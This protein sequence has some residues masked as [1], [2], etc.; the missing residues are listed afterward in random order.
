MAM[1][2]QP[3]RGFSFDKAIALGLAMIVVAV[4]AKRARAAD[5]AADVD[6]TLA[7]VARYR[8]GDDRRPLAALQQRVVEANSRGLQD[9]GGFR[10]HLADRMA[11]LL[12]S[13]DA[14]PAAKAF[15]CG[16]LAAIGTEKQAPALASLLADKELAQP[17]LAALA[18]VPG[19]VV[20]RILRDAVGTLRGDLRI[21]AVN[22]LGQR[23]DPAA[24]EVLAAMLAGTDEALACAAASALGKIGGDAA[25][26]PLLRALASAKGRVRTEVAHACLSCADRMVAEKKHEQAAVIYARLAGPGEA[27]PV[28]MAALRGTVLSQP[29]KAADVVCQAL[30]SND[31]ALESMA[32]R[33]VPE[34]P[35]PGATERFAQCLGKASLPMQKLLL[36]ALAARGDAAARSAMEAAASGQDQ[37]VRLAALGALATCGNETSVKMLMDRITAGAAAAEVEVARSSLVQLRGARVNEVLAGIISRQD[38]RAK[39]ETIRILAARDAVSAMADLKR[40]AEDPDAAVRKE[41]WKALGS[42]AREQD[43]ASLLDLVVRARNEDRDDAEK[44][45]VAVLK[46]PDRPDVRP[47]L[48]KLETT[49]SPG[50]Q[51]ALLRILSAVGDDLALPALRKAVQSAEPGVRDAAV[52]GL[53]AWPTPAPLDDLVGLAR[54]A[55]EPVHRVLALRGAIRL[56]GKASGRTPEQMTARVTELMQL[57]HV[58]AERKAVL[59]ELGRCATL[60]ALHLAQKYLADPELATEAGVAVTQIASALRDTHRDAVLK[61]LEPLL[62]GTRD[63]AVAGRACKVLKDI[64]KPVNLALGATATNPDG[65]AADGAA[66][67]PQAAIDGDPNTYWDE[68]DGADLYRLRVTFREPTE[69]AS[70]NIL[71]HPYEQHQ[72]KNFDVL[73]DGKVVKEVR[74]AKCFENEMFVA[75]APVRCTSV[76]LAIPGKNGLVSPCIHEFQI[77]GRFP[78]QALKSGAPPAPKPPQYGWRQTE[79]VLVLLNHG[80]VVWQWNYGANLGKPYFHPV[81]LTDGTVLTAPSPADHPW[82]RALWFSWKMIDGVNYWEEDA[83]TGKAKGLT[84]VRAARVVPN[85]DGSA[86]IEMD[87]GYHPPGARAVL[88]ED[89][90]IEV[91]VP[92]KQGAYRIDWRGAFTAGA[93]DVLLQGGTAGGGYAGLS[94]RISQAS[95]DWVLI[96]SEGRQ[97]DESNPP[98]PLGIAANTHGKRARWADFSLVDAA[99]ARPGGIAIL[100]HPTNPRHPSCW[101]N[102]MAAGARF[103]YF[104][105]AMLWSEPYRLAAGQRLT[106]WHRVLVHPGPAAREVVENE[107]R[108]FASL[109]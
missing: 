48:R 5:P 59:A 30:V 1:A 77:F 69:V 15:L 50:A 19:P 39:A 56:W 51:A 36:G 106:L 91:S 29:A 67:G 70:I 79:G 82:H 6:A 14:T 44:A 8:Y 78:P 22:A 60:D 21:G 12:T 86:R 88:S 42:L 76:E 41:S 64:L 75:L 53:A 24:T 99:T 31:P 61:A 16:Q 71:W 95:R 87:I 90:L 66:G 9:A 28:R 101:H 43:V 81:A 7:A 83:A 33:L 84:D 11:S 2:R 109:R 85:A 58:P 3:L 98:S 25:A 102:V 107:W 108:A 13:N 93:K 32:I 26:T 65:L 55:Q 57:A 52:R 4:G 34:V 62:G 94:V 72:A 68:V 80:R 63:P 89:R 96:D 73:C 74:G 100:D 104:S 10:R 38:P 54:H 97:D 18:Q 40:A 27:D 37:E 20:D 17:A 45:V 103:G 105:P 47:A 49:P 46:R 92:D 35:G 23:R